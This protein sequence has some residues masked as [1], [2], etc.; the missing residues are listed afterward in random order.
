MVKGSDINNERNMDCTADFPAPFFIFLP[1]S[2]RAMMAVTAMA[3]PIA[4]E[5]NRKR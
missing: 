5:Y 2:L 3:R 1:Y 4:I